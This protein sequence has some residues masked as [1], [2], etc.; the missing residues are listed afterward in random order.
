MKTTNLVISL[1]LALL[2]PAIHH[3][4]K[5]QQLQGAH[6]FFG[7]SVGIDFTAGA[8]RY[9]AGCRTVRPNDI[10]SAISSPD[11]RLRFYGSI[12]GVFNRWHRPVHFFSLTDFFDARVYLA[13][14]WPGRPTRYLQFSAHRALS[15][16]ELEV[17]PS[18]DSVIVV[19]DSIGDDTHVVPSPKLAMGA[20]AAFAHTNGTDL[21][22]VAHVLNGN[23]FLA[24]QL[25]SQGLSPTPVVSAVGMAIDSASFYPARSRI[26]VRLKASA[27]GSRLAMIKEKHGVV[28]L[29]R[30]DA[31]TGQVH[32]PRQPFT[33]NHP[34]TPLALD[35]AVDGV[36]FSPNG[37]WL[38]LAAVKTVGVPLW[39]TMYQLDLNQPDTLLWPTRAVVFAP[40][41]INQMVHPGQLGPDGRLYFT[42]DTLLNQSP[43]NPVYTG[44]LCVINC[45]DE[46]AATC[47]V[48]LGVVAFPPATGAWQP[49]V[50]NE[51]LFRNAATL[52]VVASNQRPCL[53]DTVRL[54]AVGGG[55]TG[56]TWAAAPGVP[57][58]A[59]GAVQSFVASTAG[60]YAVTGTTS[61]GAPRTAQI[62]ISPQPRPAT[63]IIVYAGGS[64]STTA[65]GP[66]QWLLNGS[67]IYGATGASYVPSRSGA[68][69]VVVGTGCTAQSAALTVVVTGLAD[70]APDDAALA[71]WPNPAA[72]ALTVRPAAAG[73]VT[74]LDALGQVVRRAEATAG[75]AV[76]W[77]LTGLAPGLYV[78]RA[79]GATRRVLVQR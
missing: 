14:E 22:L 72:D 38:Y 74:L 40:P 61:C 50:L 28:Q 27:D 46:P 29:F 42:M 4:L 75:E 62:T 2:A 51:A 49:P 55:T 26:W 59:S 44:Q 39:S 19:R 12:N 21:W 79:G 53:G 18:S 37:R 67:L 8:P 57:A 65:A 16:A 41:G 76:G 71:V 13:A 31:A 64:L 24:W 52:Q 11:G 7:D 17:V 1:L 23:Q 25:S 9:E 60:T 47:G 58:G 5:A 54:V 45:P 48:Q 30:F 35:T 34:N 66:Y 36:S 63:P 56:F 77:E 6:W 15:F 68:Y 70:A 33:I 78:V 20:F 32:S 73:V 43:I 10:A 3:P 69:A